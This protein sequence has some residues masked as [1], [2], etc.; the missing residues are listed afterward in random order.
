MSI[1]NLN[2]QYG[3]ISNVSPRRAEV[4]ERKSVALYLTSLLISSV[5]EYPTR[6]S[7]VSSRVLIE[8]IHAICLSASASVCYIMSNSIFSPR[9]TLLSFHADLSLLPCSRV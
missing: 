2:D 6:I 7:L 4:S 5:R 3:I 8:P 1:V 9:D